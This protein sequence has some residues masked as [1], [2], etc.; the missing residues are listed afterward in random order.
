M[1]YAY[2]LPPAG[3]PK[4]LLPTP[5]LLVDLDVLEAN[6]ALMAD[7][8]RTKAARLRPHFK[9]PK[10]TQIALRQMQAGAIG[11]TCAKL[12]EAEALVEAG[13]P[14]ILIANEIVDPVK[15]ARLAELAERCQLIVAVDQADNLRQIAQSARQAGSRLNVLVEVNVGMN[16]CG[17][18]PGQAALALAQQAAALEGV[19]FMGVMGY[20]GHTVNEPDREQRRQNVQQAMGA[21][22]DSANLIRRQ[23]VEV[24]I[25][26]GGGT[27]TYAETGVFA[28]MTEIQAGS[29]VFMD[30]KYSKMGLPFQPALTL[31]ATVI[32]RPTPRRAVIDMGIK[33]ATLENGLPELVSPAGARLIRL[34]EEHGILEVDLE[35]ADL[36]PSSRVELRPSHS[37]TTINLHERLYAMRGG[38]LEAIWPIEGRGKF[39]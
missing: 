15:I 35:L 1:T 19:R 33:A 22:V 25:V 26:S 18:E 36:R 20:E 9:T 21:L 39:Q 31:L 7:F 12:G 34:N 37:C 38:R 24:E 30:T 23:G 16:R 8:F 11:I 29:Y 6:L 10:C 3:S 27:G 5:A 28:G 2:L 13:I 4:E 17:V 14:S 32:S